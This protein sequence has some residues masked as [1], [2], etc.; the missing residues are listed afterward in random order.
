MFRTI[1]SVG[2]WGLAALLLISPIAAKGEDILAVNTIA[3]FAYL[4]EPETDSVLFSKNAE[5]RMYPASMSKIMTIYIAFRQLKDGLIR[6]ED[7]VLVSYKANRMGGSRMFIEEGKTVALQNILRG[8]II[9]S[10]NDASIALAEFLGGD[11]ANFAEMTNTM[12]ARLGMKGTHFVNASGWPD[13]DHYTTAKDLAILSEHLIEEFPELYRMF[14]EKTF[15]F[16]GIT[17]KN[18]NTLLGQGGIDGVKTGHTGVSGYGMV[19][20]GVQNGRRLLLV[21]NGLDSGAKRMS[22]S[23]RLL[24]LGFRLTVAT[25]F[26]DDDTHVTTLPL[27]YGSKNTISVKAVSPVTITTRTAYLENL[28]Q[29]ITYEEPLRAP[30][31]AGTKIGQLHLHTSDSVLHTV[32]LIAAESVTDKGYAQRFTSNINYLLWG[33]TP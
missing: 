18:R 13:D 32:D 7:E 21:V 23:R 22:E 3:E 27:W 6:L 17:Q 4:V 19:T 11:E 14:S 8:I 5:A 10:G 33:E 15:T 2:A 9:Q 24:D 31:K 25:T 30:I 20:S 12:A 29:T 16:S 1:S 28:T 26:Y